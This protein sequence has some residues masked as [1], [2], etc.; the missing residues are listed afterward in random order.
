MANYGMNS[1]EYNSQE[2]DRL[3]LSTNSRLNER[4]LIG[5]EPNESENGDGGNLISHSDTNNT[6]KE[7]FS[8]NSSSFPLRSANGSRNDP[9]FFHPNRLALGD[10]DSEDESVNEQ[11]ED[12]QDSEHGT[13]PR[14]DPLY[15]QPIR[16][17]LRD[18]DSE[19]EQNDVVQDSEHGDDEIPHFVEYLLENYSDQDS[20]N[21]I[22]E[23]GLSADALERLPIKHASLSLGECH[24]CFENY[25]VGDLQKVLPCFHLFHSSC[26]DQWL[27]ERATC[28]VCRTQ[29][30][31]DDD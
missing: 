26:I 17:G 2:T 28:P 1:L 9:M 24:V 4:Y 16:T 12:L 31:I 13:S 11:N 23:R 27:K 22:E 8:I 19:D 25:E 18:S 15:S 10:V 30:E 29:V 21:L 5:N 7:T 14:D 20:D 6:P 3:Q